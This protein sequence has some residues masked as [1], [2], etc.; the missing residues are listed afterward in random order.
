M[1]DIGFDDSSSDRLEGTRS[2]VGGLILK[3]NSKKTT[4]SPKGGVL[5][6]QKLAEEKRKRKLEE[7]G[8]ETKKIKAPSSNRGANHWEDSNDDLEGRAR[9]SSGR[10]DF[11]SKSRHYRSGLVETPSHTGGVD[12]EIRQKQLRRLERDRQTR[13]GG[14]YA[15]SRVQEREEKDSRKGREGY[16][17]KSDSYGDRGRRRYEKEERSGRRS[18]EH[19]DDRDSYFKEPRSSRGGWEETPY[20]SS[21]SSRDES[22]TPRHKSKGICLLST[23]S[24]RKQFTRSINPGV[25]TGQFIQCD[26][27]GEESLKDYN[28]HKSL[29][30]RHPLIN[31]RPRIITPLWL[32][33]LK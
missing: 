16:R 25:S 13:R 2:M 14:V 24:K 27:P 29:N 33:Y 23:I 8:E 31:C 17:D 19:R 20:R 9:L 5:G 12:E 10:K 4:Q 15:E 21:R 18:Q 1:S 11:K 32:K 7:D 6:L 26:T 22:Y 28:Y 30:N 3:G